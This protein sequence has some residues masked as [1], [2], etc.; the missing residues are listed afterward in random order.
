MEIERKFLPNPEAFKELDLAQYESHTIMQ[1]YIS[2]DPTIR[3]R[4]LDDSYILTVKSVALLAREEFELPLSLE[5]FE[6]LSKK[7]EDGVIE[8]TRY[9]IPLKNHTA[10]VDVFSG[11]LDGLILIEVEFDS[12]ED[13]QNFEP[14]S[15]FGEDVTNDRRFANSNLSKGLQS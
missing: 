3:I 14:P 13:S 4:R 8:K 12:L 2:R 1:A 9:L 7:T 10:E 15:W 5:Q 6:N 11:K